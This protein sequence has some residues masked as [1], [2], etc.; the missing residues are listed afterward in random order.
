MATHDWNTRI[1]DAEHIPVLRE[2]SSAR[3]APPQCGCTMGTASVL[4]SDACQAVGTLSAPAAAGHTR[5]QDE[6]QN[7]V[8]AHLFFVKPPEC[9]QFLSSL[10]ALADLAASAEDEVL[11]HAVV[12]RTAGVLRALAV[13]LLTGWQQQATQ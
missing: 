9:L 12:G 4:W 1:Y 7:R 6:R 13:V 2:A 3:P 5:C 8:M 10:A 11:A